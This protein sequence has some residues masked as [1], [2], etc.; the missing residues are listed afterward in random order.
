MV[1]EYVAKS[2][3]LLITCCLYEWECHLFLL[4]ALKKSNYKRRHD[5]LHSLNQVRL[6]P[7]EGA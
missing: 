3:I 1:N 4:T 5:E 2:D 6:L 7:L